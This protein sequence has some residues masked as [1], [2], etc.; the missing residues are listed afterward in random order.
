MYG[1]IYTIRH[2]LTV[3]AALDLLEI[4]PAS[5]KPVVVHSVVVTLA[6]SETNQ[7]VEVTLKHLPATF[8]SGSGGG[9]PTVTKQNA[10]DAAHG[11]TVEGGNTSRASTSGTVG[12]FAN[13]GFAS[14]GGYEYR[15]D[16]TERPVIKNGTGFVVGIEESLSGAEVR[17]TAVVEEL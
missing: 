1:R 8:T 3:S 6:A 14:Q 7:Q 9:T 4:A 2:N 15:P 16:V 17:V 13:E 10:D 11:F 12:Y 5:N